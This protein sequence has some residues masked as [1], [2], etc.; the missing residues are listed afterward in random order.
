MLPGDPE[1]IFFKKKQCF[2]NKQVSDYSPR[3][4][5]ITLCIRYAKKYPVQ[6]KGTFIGISVYFHSRERIKGFE[7][8]N[9]GLEVSQMYCFHIFC[10][11]K[12]IDCSNFSQ[13]CTRPFKLKSGNISDI[14]T[15]ETYSFG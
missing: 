10:S 2:I 1:S 15:K 7:S 4:F 6:H 13:K 3:Y 12:Q 9:T 14:L 11:P 5:T 8:Q